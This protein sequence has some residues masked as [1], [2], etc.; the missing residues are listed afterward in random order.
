MI[1]IIIVTILISLSI[2]ID[3][4]APVTHPRLGS[5]RYHA[6]YPNDPDSTTLLPIE[7][8]PIA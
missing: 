8:F 7:P 5:F 1:I 3:P 2:I 6:S 4:L